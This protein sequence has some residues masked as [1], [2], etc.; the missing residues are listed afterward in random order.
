LTLSDE[1]RA[2]LAEHSPGSRKL[3]LEQLAT[4]D[5]ILVTDAL[6]KLAPPPRRPVEPETLPELLGRIREDPSFPTKAADWLMRAF[7]DAKSYSGFKARCEEAWRGERPV[8]ELLDA[9]RQATGA[10]AKNPGAIFM[11]ALR[12]RS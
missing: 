9:Y 2:R 11:H 10:K 5:P 1:Q 3:I 6:A 8:A 12:P 7:D 4:G